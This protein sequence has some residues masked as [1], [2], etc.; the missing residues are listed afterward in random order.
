[1]KVTGVELFP[2]ALEGLHS[3]LRTVLP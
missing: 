1:M 2:R 3:E